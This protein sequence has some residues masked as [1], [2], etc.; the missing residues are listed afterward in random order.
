MILEHC[1]DSLKK[2]GYNDTNI[3]DAIAKGTSLSEYIKTSPLN[4]YEATR[5]M[6]CLGIQLAALH[7]INKSIVFLAP[8]HILRINQDW[9]LIQNVNQLMPIVTDQTIVIEEPI[10]NNVNY[11]APELHHITSL[12]F[13]TNISCIY[14]SIALLIKSA[15]KIK[16]PLPASNIVNSQLY[17]FLQRCMIKEPSLRR[18]LFI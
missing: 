11:L 6:M 9:Y 5:L 13:E 17:Y 15:M 7:S 3:H 14:Y 18:F 2:N 4:Y 8:H 12:P 10:I 16:E 1:I